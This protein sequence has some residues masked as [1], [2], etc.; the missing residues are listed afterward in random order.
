M[1]QLSILIALILMISE[2]VQAEKYKVS[3]LGAQSNKDGLLIIRF[4]S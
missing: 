3:Y 2:G 1:Q 4:D